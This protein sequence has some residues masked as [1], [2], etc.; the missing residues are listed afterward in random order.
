MSE[1]ADELT[2]RVMRHLRSDLLVNEPDRDSRRRQI[3]NAMEEVAGSA[4]ATNQFF[5]ILHRELHSQIVQWGET[6][7]H[8][9]WDAIAELRKFDS[10]WWEHTA[11][12]IWF[13]IGTVV[14]RGIAEALATELGEGTVDTVAVDLLVDR[15]RV[16]AAVLL[17]SG[18]NL[19]VLLNASRGWSPVLENHVL[20]HLAHWPV[21]PAE[22]GLAATLLRELVE[23]W[24]SSDTRTEGQLFKNLLIGLSS[25]HHELSDREREAASQWLVKVVL[26]R[27][28]RL[29]EDQ[30]AA[31]AAAIFLPEDR[32][33]L[34]DVPYKRLEELVLHHSEL[35]RI[36]LS[37]HWTTAVSAVEHEWS[38][39]RDKTP[40]SVSDLRRFLMLAVDETRSRLRGMVAMAVALSGSEYERRDYVRYATV[41]DENLRLLRMAEL[42]VRAAEAYGTE[43]AGASSEL[44]RLAVAHPGD[45]SSL[46]LPA[47]QTEERARVAIPLTVLMADEHRSVADSVRLAHERSVGSGRL[48]ASHLRALT[49]EALGMDAVV[50]ASLASR[51]A[52]D[53]DRGRVFPS[54]LA[55]PSSTWLS[56]EALEREL[57]DR[58]EHSGH[59]FIKEYADQF[60]SEEERLLEGYLR[61]IRDSLRTP[62][63]SWLGGSSRKTTRPHVSIE[64]RVHSKSEEATTHI[65]VALIVHIAVQGTVELRF[66]EAV[67]VKKAL[68]SADGIGF[69]RSWQIELD[70][71]HGLLGVS[72][73]PSPAA[74]PT[75]VYVFLHPERAPFV[76]PGKFILGLANARLLKTGKK[77][78]KSVTVS[79]ADLHSA[80][81]PVGQFLIDLLVG[82][83]L[84]RA[85]A[86]SLNVATGDDPF[87]RPRVTVEV[88]LRRTAPSP[89]DS[90]RR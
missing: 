44:E 73:A 66:A 4:E 62:R 71:L 31:A 52:A 22:A 78:Q 6:R 8:V 23:Q 45:W 67:Q 3:F 34:L 83:W 24:A 64:T 19:S 1:G 48:R 2:Q 27:R 89:D 65:D 39:S 29:D 85:D 58:V 13:D 26:E 17:N 74:F 75:A 15:P 33:Q 14:A 51:I 61:E 11:D 50:N 69:K 46:L 77:S 41:Q 38:G 70:Q 63:S 82:A 68:R 35:V 90:E 12:A 60:G 47:L 49:E 36:A 56:D 18:S 20:L 88:V 21:E 76:V 43:A 42:L 53:L 54:P 7:G 10:E 5:A 59:Q 55:A 87:L 72:P 25:R 80:A 16:F 32:A 57:R 30:A 9:W 28:L 79:Y 84:G 81:I 37:T 86:G 40:L